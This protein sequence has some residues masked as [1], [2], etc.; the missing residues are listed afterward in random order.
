AIQL[1]LNA[2]AGKIL[3]SDLTGNA[4]W[5]N[6]VIAPPSNYNGNVGY[7]VWGDCTINGNISEYQPI[8]DP[9]PFYN[10]R[11]GYSVSLSGD[12]AVI[13]AYKDST[14]IPGQGSAS[15]FA[16]NG[17]S[18]EFLQKL[19]DP[20]PDSTDQFGYCVS[21]S[22][23]FIIIGSPSDNA[24]F[25]N[26]G[27]VCFFEFNGT[28]WNFME[29]IYQAG[30]FT[31]NRFGESVFISGERAIV[32]A[33]FTNAAQGAASIYQFDGTHWQIMNQVAET[34]GSSADYFGTSVGIS[35]DMAVVGVKGDDIG[36]QEDAGSAIVYQYNGTNWTFMQKLTIYGAKAFDSFGS[37][38][39]ISGNNLLI[40][41]PLIDYEFQDQGAA[42][43]YSFNGSDWEG[44]QGFTQP[45]SNLSAAFGT[46][47]YLSGQFAMVGS[48]F[49]IRSGGT[50]RS[51]SADLY[52]KIGLGWQ[53]MQ[54]VFD[55]DIETNEF[56]YSVSLDSDTR[57]FI[58]GAFG[59]ILISG[60]VVFGKVN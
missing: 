34:F 58:I 16:F 56:G 23:D 19:T 29:K 50:L 54:T 57:R 55:P 28:S 15:V 14:F 1:A 39:A 4:S 46:S 43:M 5:E 40:G 2:G 9:S 7:G 3:T 37:A 47:V 26:Q 10:E 38:V 49:H 8:T 27:S 53:N 35:G 44:L 48:P 33:P 13:G 32:G 20:E 6:L 17:V 42:V 21:I 60:K 25:A 24:T 36:N 51:G 22:G 45:H 41:I 12:Y 31:G 59:Y 11:F 30:A 52:Q 18:W